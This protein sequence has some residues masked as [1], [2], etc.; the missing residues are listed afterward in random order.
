M[1]VGYGAAAVAPNIAIAVPAVVAATIGNGAA[2]VCNSL[3]VQR[4]VPDRLRGR[5]FTLLMSSNFA[6][7]GAGMLLAGPATDAIGPRA[8]WGIAAGVMAVAA[9]LALAL[10]RGVGDRAGETPT[11]VLVQEREVEAAG[12][13]A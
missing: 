8:V 2:V 5:A 7:L 1:A 13:P 9:G 4:G 6:V 11:D 10:T 3:L 12:R